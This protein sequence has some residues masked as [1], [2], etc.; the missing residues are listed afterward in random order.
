MA[1]EKLIEAQKLI[2]QT[3]T[4]WLKHPPQQPYAIVTC[5]TIARV[6]RRIITKP[7]DRDDAKRILH[8]LSGRRHRVISGL[9]VLFPNH[10]TRVKLVE[11]HV[12]FKSLHDQEIEAY[13]DTDEWKNAAGAYQIQGQAEPLIRW[14]RGS[15]SN[16]I[17]LPLFDLRQILLS[18]HHASHAPHDESDS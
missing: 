11:T 8:L 7:Q 5:D 17:G 16:I 14:M 1:L 10:I 4:T 2:A 6:G 3:P 18:Y 13:L 12:A 9:A 15:Y